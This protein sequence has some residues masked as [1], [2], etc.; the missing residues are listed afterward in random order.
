MKAALHNLGCKVNAYETEAMQQI[1]EEAGYEIVP[2][3]EYADVYVINTC[4]VT[5]MADRKSRQM[6]HR[7]KKQNP[8]A[9]VVGA[10]CY[11]QTKEAQA[12]VDES[13][14]IVIGNNKKHELVPHASGI[15]SIPPQDGVCGGYQ[16]REAGIRGIVAFSARQSTPE[17]LSR[18][19]MAAISSAHTVLFRLREGVSE[20]GSFRTSYRRYGRWQKAATARWCSP[21]S[22]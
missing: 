12:L 4:S 8:D 22:I 6:L 7:A 10:G 1:L 14:D 3:S 2:F 18:C 20:A 5:N 15:R 9:I 11:V 16:S 21:E 19:R 17:R 13:I